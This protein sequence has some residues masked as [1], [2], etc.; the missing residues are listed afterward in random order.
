[1]PS[2]GRQP[3]AWR[4]FIF[5]VPAERPA[6][7]SRWAAS[8]QDSVVLWH[9]LCKYFD[10]TP[11]FLVGNATWEIL[12][13]LYLHGTHS[14]ALPD[15]SCLSLAYRSVCHLCPGLVMSA[16]LLVPLLVTMVNMLEPAPTAAAMR[17]REMSKQNCSCKLGVL[18]LAQGPFKG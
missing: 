17:K 4:C 11:N 9:A 16:H 2:F 7:C 13:M 8:L 18:C 1:M 6:S 15:L 3:Q 14:P 12:S 5:R 10:Y